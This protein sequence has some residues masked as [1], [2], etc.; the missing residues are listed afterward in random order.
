MANKNLRTLAALGAM[1]VG[2]LFVVTSIPTTN[3]TNIALGL[4]IAVAGFVY[5]G[6]GLSKG[7][8]REKN[9]VALDLIA[10]ALIAVFFLTMLLG[11][12]SGLIGNDQPTQNITQF[13]LLMEFGGL[14]LTLVSGILVISPPVSKGK[15]NTII[16]YITANFAA[17]FLLN[18]IVPP[19]SYRFLG[20]SIAPSSPLITVLISIPEETVF[21]VWLAPWLA[22]ISKTGALGGSFMQ[23]IVATVYHLF[24]L[25]T[26]P[27][28]LG[29]VFGAFFIAGFT[30]I[31]ARYA[32]VTFTN[33]LVNNFLS[34]FAGI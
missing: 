32:S 19:A 15:F 20:L 6:R 30:A 1:T 21:H 5:L 17:F 10:V 12:L 22:N 3:Y 2:G 28:K 7:R 34:V 4:G 13:L 16:L 33:H 9:V 11:A 29:I 8:G 14:L 26:Q 24:V 27:A 23:G 18:L 31:K 25:G